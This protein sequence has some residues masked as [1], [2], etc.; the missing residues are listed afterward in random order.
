MLRFSGGAYL[1]GESRAKQVGCSGEL[2]AMVDVVVVGGGFVGCNAALSLAERGVSVALCEKGAIAGEASGR[3]AG[4]IECAHF[5]PIKLEM[6]ARSM[7]LW[8]GMSDRIGRDIGYNGHGLLSFFDDEAGKEGAESWLQSVQGQPGVDARI[9]SG[10]EVA[11]LDPALGSSWCGA[12]YQPNGATVEPKLAAPAIAEAAQEKGAKL[13]QHCSVRGIKLEAGR[14]AGVITEKGD[15]K[16]SNV[17]IAGGLWSPMLAKQLNLNVPQ[18]MVFAEMLSVEPLADGPELCGVTPAGVFRREPDGGYTFGAITGVVPVTPTMLK[19]LRRLMA[20][21]TDGQEMTPVFNWRTFLLEIGCSKALK[22]GQ[23]SVF[24]K[25]R[26]FQPEFV[27]ETSTATYEG[28]GRYIPSF[29]K[30]RIRE[31]YSGALMS[32]L[33]NLGVV[34]S[35]QDIPG[36]FLGTGMLHGLTMGPAAGEALADMITG[37]IPKFDVSPYRHERFTDGSKFEFYP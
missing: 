31:R 2:P 29:R 17:V 20:M 25:N 3:A 27:G 10:E 1:Q 16:T 18:L 28:M 24:E 26:V 15:I 37:E 34:S 7:E 21:Q 22:P 23:P 36:L 19:N 4:L 6:V 12:L 32:T 33:D 11:A 35:I 30:S 8:C 9:V 5:A 13:L 14:I